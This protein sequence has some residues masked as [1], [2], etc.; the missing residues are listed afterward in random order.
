[1]G[2][3]LE[4]YRAAI[5]LHNSRIFRMFYFYTNSSTSSAVVFALML[6]FY[7]LIIC[8]SFDVHLNPG[9]SSNFSLAHL[10]ARSLLSENKFDQISTFL[11]VYNFD[12]FGLTETW[13]NPNVNEQQLHMNGYHLPLIKNRI[14]GRGGGVALY[15]ADYLSHKRRYEFEKP[16][17]ELL[18]CEVI[19]SNSRF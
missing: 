14:Y 18:W 5:G 2:D 17:L 7:T 3:S 9:P 11:G 1:M 4:S 13:L 12:A 15:L 19:L 10:N 8:L 6:A 16:D